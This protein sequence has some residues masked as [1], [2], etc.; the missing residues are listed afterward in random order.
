LFDI[1]LEVLARAIMQGKQAK[2]MQAG[3][4]EANTH[5]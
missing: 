5:L 2:K 4:E 1:L 3:K